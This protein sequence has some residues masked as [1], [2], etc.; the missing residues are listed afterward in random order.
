MRVIHSNG[1]KPGAL[2]RKRKV[3]KY[4]CT[5]FP[6]IPFPFTYDAHARSEPKL[7]TCKSPLDVRTSGSLIIRIQTP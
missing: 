6:V 4:Y 2:L 5:V 1:F 3:D 7:N